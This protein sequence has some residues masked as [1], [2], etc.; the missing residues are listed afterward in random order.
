LISES[1]LLAVEALRAAGAN[2][3]EMAAIFTYGFAVA[4]DN[5]KA[6]RFDTLE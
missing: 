6:A 2:I 3:K 5:F 1:S 4:E